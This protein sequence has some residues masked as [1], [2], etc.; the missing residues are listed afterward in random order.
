MAI[1]GEFLKGVQQNVF[2]SGYNYH[3]FQNIDEI[4]EAKKLVDAV[5]VKGDVS[6]I[7]FKSL[8]DSI[9]LGV[10]HE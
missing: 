5:L 8:L 9:E 2:N 10:K 4:N 3:N 7:E 1:I 6:A